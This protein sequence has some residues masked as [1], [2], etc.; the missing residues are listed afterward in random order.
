MFY[1]VWFLFWFLNDQVSYELLD[2][3]LK[4]NHQIKHHISQSQ[5]CDTVKYDYPFCA[6]LRIQDTADTSLS[7]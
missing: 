2:Q 3:P 1:H 5:A 6:R 4:N 7:F